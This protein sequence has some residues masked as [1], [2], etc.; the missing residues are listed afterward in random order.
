M[1]KFK[2]K[3][4][5]I[6]DVKQRLEKKTQKELSIIELEISN[7]KAELERLMQLLKAQKTKKLGK[8]SKTVTEFHFDEKYENYLVEQMEIIDKYIEAKN[9]ERENK[10]EEL[11]GRAK[12]TKTFEKLEEK[13]FSEFIKTQEKLDQVE[14]DEFAV[15]EFLKG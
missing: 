4:D 9:I 10:L 2:Y 13:H 3:F 7:K 1:A 5:S 14:M 6:K 15:Q 8:Q 12:E 11:V